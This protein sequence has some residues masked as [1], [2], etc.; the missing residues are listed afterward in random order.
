MLD[1]PKWTGVRPAGHLPYG[2]EICSQ[3]TLPTQGGY[4]PLPEVLRKGCSCSYTC[5]SPVT[6]YFSCHWHIVVTELELW[7][8]AMKL[9]PSAPGHCEG[10]WGFTKLKTDPGRCLGADWK[11]RGRGRELM[12]WGSIMVLM[13]QNRLPSHHFSSWW[14]WSMWGVRLYGAWTHTSCRGPGTMWAV[15]GARAEEASFT[16][17]VMSLAKFL[18]TQQLWELGSQV[19]A[20]AFPSM[21][22]RKG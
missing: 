20:M 16:T 1:S 9:L 19:L 14:H 2:A 17:P 22:I 7:S 10:H 8:I 13:L 11:V 3:K 4:V 15:T 18:K 21:L 6:P 12:G 5:C